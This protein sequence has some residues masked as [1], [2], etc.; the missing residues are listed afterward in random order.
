[1]NKELKLAIQI[2]EEQLNNNSSNKAFLRNVSDLVN[3]RIIDI[4]HNI[5]NKQYICVK[6]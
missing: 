6:N 1:M 4:T 3:K 2:K 5:R